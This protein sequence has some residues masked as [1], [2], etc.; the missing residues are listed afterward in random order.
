VAGHGLPPNVR[1]ANEIAVQFG[2]VPA[3]R[4]AEEV[5]KH[6]RSFWEPRMLADLL[7]RVDAGTP[8]LEPVAR[9]A[10]ERL[11]QPA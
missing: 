6:M 7:A 5:A 8:E 2:H 10:V 3:E 1:L 11:R 4:A 9:A